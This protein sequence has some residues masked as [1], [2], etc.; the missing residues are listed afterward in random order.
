VVSQL[1]IITRTLAVLEQRVSQNEDM[2][3]NV[4]DKYQSVKMQAAKEN[5]AAN[6]NMAGLHAAMG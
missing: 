6:F 5:V 2:V 1:E 3:S 4:L